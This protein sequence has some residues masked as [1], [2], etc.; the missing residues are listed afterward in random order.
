LRGNV[1]SGR[2]QGLSAAGYLKGHRKKVDV[3]RIGQGILDSAIYLYPSERAANDGERVGGSGF[4]MHVRDTWALDNPEVRNMVARD[5]EAASTYAVTNWHVIGSGGTVVRLNLAMSN[6]TDTIATNASDW[7]QHP[8]GDDVAVLPI[9]LPRKRYRMACIPLTMCY[10]SDQE[11]RTSPSGGRAE[12]LMAGDEAFFVG[13]FI[14]YDGKQTNSPTARFGNLITARTQ[15]V[16]SRLGI[17]Q[18]SFLVEARSMSGYSGSPVFAYLPYAV[19][20]RARSDR[21]QADLLRLA[22]TG[23]MPTE[24]YVREGPDEVWLI[25]ID[26]GHLPD[27]KRVL[28]R[29]KETPV[30]DE[31]Y[32]EQN[33]GVMGVVPAWKIRE[34]LEGETLVERRKK[35]ADERMREFEKRRSEGVV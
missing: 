19:T 4:L 33:S 26:H 9:T 16:P 1:L 6:G 13:R 29:D 11:W 22:T 12:R 21:T 35:E 17:E 31:W 5:P 2:V 23:S 32:V 34:I 28:E 8:D 27:H 20:Q 18:E 15:K 10:P 24:Q 3:P 25:G 14:G 30:P 7:I